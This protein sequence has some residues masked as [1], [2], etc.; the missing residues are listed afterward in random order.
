[1]QHFENGG[2]MMRVIEKLLKEQH[3]LDFLNIVIEDYPGRMGQ[4][5]S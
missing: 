5:S 1:M 2:D 4:K 3:F